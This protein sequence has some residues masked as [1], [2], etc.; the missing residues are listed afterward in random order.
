M[1][2]G[3]L[4]HGEFL[5]GKRCSVVPPEYLTSNGQRRGKA[6]EGYRS[7]H[8]A[9]EC[10][11]EKELAAVQ[12]IRASIESQSIVGNV[13]WGK[14]PTELSLFAT[15]VATGLQVKGRIDKLRK[16]ERLIIGDLKVTSIDVDDERQVIGK[17]WSMQYIQQA[18]FYVDLVRVAT[19][20]RPDF[21]FIFARNKPPYTVRLWQ[22][23]DNDLDLGRRR[24]EAALTDLRRRLDS[25]DW[26]GDRTNRINY[27]P[28]GSLL[29][30][31]AFEGGDDMP[32]ISYDNDFAAFAAQPE[33]N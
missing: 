1:L 11:S 33:E 23:G 13:L 28:D 6:Y 21:L 26:S 4:C 16:A 20:K 15:H 24:N 2:F 8:G 19:G 32:S 22:P 10:L 7:C 30:R 12:G 18:A 25:G 5:E 17:V 14:G 27:G 3:T 9:L 29:P 31:W